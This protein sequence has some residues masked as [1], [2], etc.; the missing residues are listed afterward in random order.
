MALARLFYALS[1]PTAPVVWTNITTTP[2]ATGTAVQL[3]LEPPRSELAK[4]EPEPEP[5]S[6]VLECGNC[7]NEIKSAPVRSATEGSRT[8]QYFSC[9]H[10]GMTVRLVA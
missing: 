9:E 1:K 8:A 10:C 4:S 7:H 2:E 6:A 3:K 5:E